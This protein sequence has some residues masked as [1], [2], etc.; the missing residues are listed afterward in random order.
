MFPGNGMDGKMIHVGWHYLQNV[1]SINKTFSHTR[2]DT[3]QTAY[4]NTWKSK[5]VAADDI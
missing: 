2:L 4:C 3:T 1:H 5:I